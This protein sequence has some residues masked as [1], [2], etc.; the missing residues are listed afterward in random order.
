[1]SNNL[2]HKAIMK[3]ITF[4]MPMCMNTELYLIFT[5]LPPRNHVAEF[6]NGSAHL[7]QD[8]SRVDAVVAV[9]KHDSKRSWYQST[10]TSQRDVVTHYN[11]VDV[12]SN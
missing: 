6:F 1:M 5:G 4:C 8:K 12:G 9:H 2:I 11:V 10:S 3:L 7:R